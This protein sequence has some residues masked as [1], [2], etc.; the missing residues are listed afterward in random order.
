MVEGEIERSV[1]QTMFLFIPMRR[2]VVMSILSAGIYQVYWM[3]KNWNYLK[4][5][6]YSGIR[7]FWRGIFGVF[8]CHDLLMTIHT[9]FEA[10]KILKAKFAWSGLA[11]GWVL[12]MVVAGLLHTYH[13]YFPSS[14]VQ[15]IGFFAQLPAFL[16]LVPVQQYVNNVNLAANQPACRYHG[17]SVGHI[18]C[19]A[20]GLI[21]WV[22]AINAIRLT[23]G[24]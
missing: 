18:V 12:L 15:L 9:D 1:P 16:F 3:Y 19:L 5:R 20:I 13:I 6:G 11:W 7:P 2:L 17:W 14:A 23:M 24:R 10:N 4:Q 21:A 8:F 22:G